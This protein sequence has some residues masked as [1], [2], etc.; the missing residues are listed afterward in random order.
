M[1]W[2]CTCQSCGHKQFARQ[3]PDKPFKNEGERERWIERHRKCV[4]CKSVDLD[5]GSDNTPQVEED[6]S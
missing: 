3:W 2:M 4:K 5:F 6:E 1:S